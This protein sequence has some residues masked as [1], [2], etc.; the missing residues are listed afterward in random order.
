MKHIS[1]HETEFFCHYFNNGKACPFDKIGCK[2]RH[3]NSPFCIS[4]KSKRVLCPNKH[5]KSY[6]VDESM[7]RGDI[8]DK[9]N[10]NYEELL[11]DINIHARE[12]SF[13]TSTPKK[14]KISCEGCIGKSKCEDCHLDEYVENYLSKQKN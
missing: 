5:K 11:E 3:E 4:K 7:G 14:R 10:D 13:V 9:E 1:G 12:E 2:F 6:D 8:S